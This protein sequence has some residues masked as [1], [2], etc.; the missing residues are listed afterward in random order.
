MRRLAFFFAIVGA[1][2]L[3]A[4]CSAGSSPIFGGGDGGDLNPTGTGTTAGQGGHGGGS[5]GAGGGVGGD[6]GTS[7]GTTST[8]GTGG[9]TSTTPPPCPDGTIQ[10]DG[11]TKRVCDGNGGF[12]ETVDCSTNICVPNI[13]CAVCVPNTGSCN[14][15][16]GTTCK[17][18]GSGFVDEVCDA[19]QGTTCNAA[20]GGCDGVCSLGQL[21]K[22]YI[23]CD[24]WPTI[25]SNTQLD[26]GF[27]F[28]VAVSNTTSSSATVTVT[29]G[30]TTVTTVTID[31]NSVQVVPLPWISELKDPWSSS[32]V[33]GGAYRLRST[34]PVTVYQFNPLEYTKGGGFTYTNDASLLLPSTAWTGTYNVVAW[35]QWNGLSG[36]YAIVASENGTT[37]NIAAPPG[38]P[39]NLVQEGVPGLAN[40]GTGTVTL[41][42]GD[43]AQVLSASGDV[44]GTLVMADKPVQVIGGHDCTNVPLN[45]PYCD[46]IEE[47]ILPYETLS[48][49]Y[50][51]TAPLISPSTTKVRVVRILATKPNTTL[52]YDP[53]QGA[54]GSIAQAG[55]LI[56]IPNTNADFAITANEPIVVMEYMEGQDAG[57]GT[58]D[59]AMAISIGKEQYRKSYLF[60]APTNYEYSFANVVCPTG[61]TAVLD[62][63]ALGGF[64]GV[65]ASGF[66]VARVQLSNAG[67]GNHTLSSDLACGVSVYGYGQYT[68][69]WYPGGSDLTRLHD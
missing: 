61:T 15:E 45:I 30:A 36:L 18:D 39:F 3:L 7:S 43:V 16:V 64:T 9:S 65:G 44:T 29:R 47:S 56:E 50:I 55:Q 23:G 34:Q 17:S 51:V 5:G 25:T 60:H 32:I 38:A 2:A 48:N 58:G 53:P 49:A 22:S 27:T 46:H 68:S 26:D 10:C 41:N 6:W 12:K 1:G 57:G 35:P 28:A 19:L 31:P 42:A 40:T 33:A 4:A 67:N 21:G 13:G 14:G 11:V 20:T 66:A 52:T 54:P 24:Y 63:A 37:V 62:G 59:P 69:Y 8:A